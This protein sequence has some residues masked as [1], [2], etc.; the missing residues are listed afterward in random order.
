MNNLNVVSTGAP[1]LTF[2]YAVDT[3]MQEP[4]P[5]RVR[6]IF[7]SLLSASLG[8]DSDTGYRESEEDAA[9]RSWEIAMEEEFGRMV[10]QRA[11]ALSAA[12][13]GISADVPF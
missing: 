11:V 6:A 8:A 3:L 13:C 4:D 12:A 1:V 5:A 7:D 2:N 10:E 9:E